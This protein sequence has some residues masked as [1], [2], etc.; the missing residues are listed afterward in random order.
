[1][2]FFERGCDFSMKN[3]KTMPSLKKGVDLVKLKHEFC[4]GLIIAS[5]QLLG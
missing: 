1:M 4:L 3:S 2:P 5:A